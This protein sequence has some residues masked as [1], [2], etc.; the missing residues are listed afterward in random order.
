MAT[1]K[2]G[3]PVGRKPDAIHDIPQLHR[4]DPQLLPEK[5]LHAACV[6]LFVAGL[7]TAANT[8]A[9]M[10]HEVL[11]HPDVHA[12]MQAE[13]DELFAGEGPTPE[14]LRQLDVTIDR[15]LPDRNEHLAPG[16]YAPFGLGTHRCLGGRFAEVQLAIIAATLVHRVE[17]AL[18]PPDFKLKIR[19]SPLLS[20]GNDFKTRVERRKP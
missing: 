11:R 10:L 18:N 12:R 5:D 15:Y 16:V 9:F 2:G 7:H 8:A 1:H 6:G 4:T 19:H 13:A 3:C 20:P 14:K 17:S